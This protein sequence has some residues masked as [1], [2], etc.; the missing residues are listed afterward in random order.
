MVRFL[1]IAMLIGVLA[2]CQGEETPEVTQSISTQ[3]AGDSRVAK[4]LFGN[5]PNTPATRLG[6]TLTSGCCRP[7]V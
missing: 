6:W 5:V 1:G 7:T 3:N 2:A 4:N